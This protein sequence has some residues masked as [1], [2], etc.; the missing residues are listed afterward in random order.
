M[1]EYKDSAQELIDQ[2]NIMPFMAW[3]ARAKALIG[4]EAPNTKAELLDILLE[5]V[6]K[7]VE[8]DRDAPAG[9]VEV[10]LIKKY[11]PFKVMDDDG[12]F[13]DQA[14]PNGKHVQ[15]ASLVSIPAGIAYLE[16][17]E[18]ERVLERGQATPTRNTFRQMREVA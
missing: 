7:P 17:R 4:E 8:V 12:A 15:D 16:P 5:M 18:A 2:A 6:P 1:T 3:K 9:A 11:T 13:V 10:L 14:L